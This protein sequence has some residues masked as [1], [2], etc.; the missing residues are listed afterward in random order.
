[1]TSMSPRPR[2][3]GRGPAKP[4]AVLAF[5]I[6]CSAWSAD[7]ALLPAVSDELRGRRVGAFQTET[8][9]GRPFSASDL[10]GKPAIINSAFGACLVLIGAPVYFFYRHKT[11]AAYQGQGR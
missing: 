7:A 9:D 8:L 3:H 11:R 4:S 10:R 5:A 1:M 2:S 6:A